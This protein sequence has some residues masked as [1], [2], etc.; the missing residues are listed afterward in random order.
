MEHNRFDLITC[1]CKRTLRH[2]TAAEPFG[3]RTCLQDEAASRASAAL[4]WA[5][6]GEKPVNWSE[7]AQERTQPMDE[8]EWR[9]SRKR[10]G[11]DD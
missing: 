9:L 11:K 6:T 7:V 10:D 2:R 4:E 5:L 1:E 8:V 3:C